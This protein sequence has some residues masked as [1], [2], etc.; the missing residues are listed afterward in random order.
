MGTSP[1]II[2]Q[3]CDDFLTWTGKLDVDPA[4]GNQKNIISPF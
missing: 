2:L 1:V 3:V 4:V